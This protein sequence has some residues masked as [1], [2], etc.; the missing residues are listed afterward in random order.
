MRDADRAGEA[1]LRR[2]VDA[3]V[4]EFGPDVVGA[5]ALG[6]LAHGGFAP[7][8]SDVDLMLVLG[9]VDGSTRT[10]VDRIRDRVRRAEAT[11]LAD[12]LSLFWSDRRG[13]L[14]GAGEHSRLPE[15]DRLDLLDSGRLLY[16]EDLRYGAERPLP[17]T[18]AVQAAE[19]ALVKFDDRYLASLERPAEL[20][21]S[22]PRAVT[23]A[24]L[25]PVRFLY[26]LDTGRIGHNDDAARWF[27]ARHAH[28]ELVTAAMTWR[29][30][31]IDGPEQAQALL[32]SHLVPI[33]AHLARSY[34][35]GLNAIGRPD[36]GARMADRFARSHPGT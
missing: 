8:V 4:D 19:F 16:G 26:T 17:E 32:A 15:V 2:A 20:I 34:E 1:V 13:I 21:R 27:S 22:G 9:S 31:G 11:D 12:R 6:S 23:K 3:A 18:L 25:F 36:L 30:A 35:A 29:T 7:L 24:V 28:G 33:Y 5:F 10:R 14:V